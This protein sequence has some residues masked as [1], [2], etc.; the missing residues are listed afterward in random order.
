MRTI[1][2]TGKGG[3]GKTSIAAAT[4]AD[5]AGRGMKVLIMSTD[6]AHS[7]SDSFGVQLKN[8][9]QKIAENLYGMEI[10]T[11]LENEKIWGRLQ[12]YMRL[13]M[14]AKSEDT[15]ESEEL[16]VFPGFEELLSLIKIKE[17]DDEGNFDVLI[18]DC[19]PTGETMSLLK[20][21]DLFKVWMEKI[22]PIKKKGVKYVRPIVEPV[23][24]IPMPDDGVFDDIE[25]LYEKIDYLHKLI[26]D[27]EKVSIRIVTTPEKIV[28][29]EAKRS[30]SYLHLFDYNVDAVIIN[31]IFPEESTKGYFSRWQDMQKESIKDVEESFK[32]MP[33]LKMEL[34]KKEING[35]DILKTV[36]SSLYKKFQAEDVLFKDNIFDVKSDGDNYIFRIKLPF[37]NKEEMDLIQNGDELTI[38]IKNEKRTFVVPKKL[39]SKC[40]SGARYEDGMLNI[41]F[42]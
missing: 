39:Q 32:G 8:E 16:L 10:D 35:Y 25:K 9:T 5:I 22:F 36:G 34:L 41:I 21:P 31:K 29:K 23:L 2:Y 18:V 19:A 1:L 17:L 7:L 26:L 20:F 12:S 14:S 24:K 42:N 4:A 11:V 27:K 38:A 28:V 30:F 3:V 37:V 6:A 40:V 15:I 33:V 13:L